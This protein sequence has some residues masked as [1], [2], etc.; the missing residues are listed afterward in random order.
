MQLRQVTAKTA[1]SSK[2][3]STSYMLFFRFEHS[4]GVNPTKILSRMII[5]LFWWGCI[6]VKINVKNAISTALESITMVHIKKDSMAMVL[7]H[8][9][10]F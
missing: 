7:K 2:N 6:C 5:Y 8:H 9:T 3:I 10:V 1:I 4:F